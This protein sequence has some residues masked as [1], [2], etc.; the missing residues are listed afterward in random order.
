[1]NRNGDGATVRVLLRLLRDD[2]DDA[3]FK[4]D[5][6]PLEQARVAEA[7]PRV[8]ADHHEEMPLRAAFLRGFMEAHQL[9]HRE[10]SA[11]DGIVGAEVHVLPRIGHHPGFLG[12]D[13]EYLAQGADVSV[14]CA[15]RMVAA[16][17][18]K[19]LCDRRRG[20]LREVGDFGMVVFDPAREHH[21]HGTFRA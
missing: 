18:G 9:V 10:F 21:P 14:V 15:C 6:L 11:A 7:Q 17:L 20:D 16:E 2:L 19:I 1:M 13:A 3:A 8:C 4:V 12:E 5:I